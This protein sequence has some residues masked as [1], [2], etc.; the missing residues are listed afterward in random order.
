MK[1]I[2]GSYMITGRFIREIRKRKRMTQLELAKKVGISQAHIAKIELE[3]VD[4]RLS[5]VN[6]ILSV[7]EQ[8]EFIKCE[9]LMIKKII[10]VRL[11]NSIEKVIKL[12]KRFGISQLPVMDNNNRCV[13]IITEKIIIDNLDKRLST[14]QVSDI[15]EKDIPIVNHNDDINIAKRML[16]SHPA[17]L[18]SKNEKIVGIIT[19]SD[20]LNLLR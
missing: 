4:P 13:G 16:E 11:D 2:T 14:L 6:K 3:K 9:D 19:K 18:V 17:V 7:L 15:Y 20:L 8:K 12:M 1:N 10:S 5:T